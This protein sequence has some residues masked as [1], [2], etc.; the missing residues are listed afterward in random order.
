MRA[1]GTEFAAATT[2][3]EAL[4]DQLNLSAEQA[5]ELMKLSSASSI[6]QVLTDLGQVQTQLAVEGATYT[7]N[8][9]I[10]TNLQRQESA[11][12][13]LLNERVTDVVG[14][15]FSNDVGDYEFS[16]IEA[17]L[18]SDL[19]QAQVQQQAIANSIQSL[20]QDRL[21][22][23]RR[24]DVL[25]SLEREQLQLVTDLQTAQRD[26][27]LLVS[28]LQEVRLAE[29]QTLGT[30]QIQELAIPPENPV[31]NRSRQMKLLLA[32]IA[33]GVISG[34][35]LA[36]LLDLLDKSI[37]TAKDPVANPEIIK[38]A[39]DTRSHS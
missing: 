32:G 27:D 9:P 28:R 20:E 11:L 23:V 30:A 34:V 31:S 6:Q 5:Q 24:S 16:P 3:V 36:F 14:R 22:Y 33:A 38:V 8:H 26:Y 17:Q 7:G 18:T 21:D 2:Q 39:A 29:N 37:K 25:P 1:L 19:L 13:S 4:R 10:V 15:S 35:A 12:V